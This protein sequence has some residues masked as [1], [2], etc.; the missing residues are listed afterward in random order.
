MAL[1]LLLWMLTVCA[2]E[3]QDLIGKVLIVPQH[4]PYSYL[5]VSPSNWKFDAVTLCMRIFLEP[6]RAHVM[7]SLATPAVPHDFLILK[8]PEDE[9]I[10]MYVRNEATSF[11]F[12]DIHPNRWNTYCA[13]WDHISGLGQLWLNGNPSIRKYIS[14][15][16]SISGPPSII[17]GQKQDNYGFGFDPS[18]SF[19]GMMTDVHMW[20]YTI[21][22]C[23]IKR[24]TEGQLFTPGNVLNWGAL[25]FQTSGRVLIEEKQT[26]CP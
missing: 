26:V 9:V 24:Y 10:Q 2:A 1:L 19:V 7:F 16:S 6:G 22:H 20:N 12:L 8:G 5:E 3:P 15:G 4:S 17:L 13:T 18:Q 14:S 21:S 11:R 23:E 25:D